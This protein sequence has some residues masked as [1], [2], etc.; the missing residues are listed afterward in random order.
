MPLQ[1][2]RWSKLESWRG[3]PA[4]LA[5]LP[6]PFRVNGQEWRDAFEHL[7]NRT[8]VQLQVLLG[9]CVIKIMTA[10][11][12]RNADVVLL[13][14]E[15]SQPISVLFFCWLHGLCNPF[16]SSFAPSA[17]IL[18]WTRRA[19]KFAWELLCRFYALPPN[20]CVQRASRHPAY[21]VSWNSILY[22]LHVFFKRS[23]F[24]GP[25]GLESPK[26]QWHSTVSVAM[27]VS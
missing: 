9:Q 20:Q 12:P 25:T 6:T 3:P 15:F 16:L 24:P 22:I 7:N 26:A 14:S 19:T 21:A 27:S 13:I 1:L 4:M 10:E 8:E 5:W 17:C 18:H 2:R 11:I 23:P